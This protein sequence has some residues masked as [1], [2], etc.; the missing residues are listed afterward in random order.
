MV[1]FL[2]KLVLLLFLAVAL[3]EN[4]FSAMNFVKNLICKCMRDEFLNDC[5][6]TYV[7]V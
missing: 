6:V 1:Y 7:G 4:S 3:V 5:L 2:L